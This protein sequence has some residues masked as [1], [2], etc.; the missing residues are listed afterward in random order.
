M[1]DRS[2]G[3]DTGSVDAIAVGQDQVNVEA[4]SRGGGQQ[5]STASRPEEFKRPEE[6]TELGPPQ[7]LSGTANAN[8]FKR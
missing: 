6:L 7:L 4:G 8:P 3:L 1:G 2:T 5:E